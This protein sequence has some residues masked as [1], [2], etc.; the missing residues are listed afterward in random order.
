MFIITDGTYD[1]SSHTHLVDAEAQLER[2]NKEG[3]EIR[4]VEADY[5]LTVK[6]EGYEST[7]Q[8]QESK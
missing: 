8:D 1:F 6:E 3:L 5:I 4:E 2:F 7:T